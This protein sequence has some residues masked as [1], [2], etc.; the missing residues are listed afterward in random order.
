MEVFDPIYA[1]S[2]SSLSGFMKSMAKNTKRKIRYNELALGLIRNTN[3]FQQFTKNDLER[4]LNE[5][6][7][8]EFGEATEIAKICFDICQPHWSYLNGQTI[9]LNGG[10]YTFECLSRTFQ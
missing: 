1:S 3:M 9:H 10:S 5:I 7:I 8:A 4:H 6:P 2:K